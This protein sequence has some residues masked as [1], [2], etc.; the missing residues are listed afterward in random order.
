MKRK[1]LG[2]DPDKLFAD[3]ISLRLWQAIFPFTLMVLAGF[4][5]IFLYTFKSFGIDTTHSERFGTFVSV[6]GLAS[7]VAGASLL[8]GG[9]LGFLFGVP[10]TEDNEFIQKRDDDI[11]FSK[12]ENEKSLTRVSRTNIRA[13]TNLEQISD[14]LTKILVGVGLTQIKP[15]LE[16]IYAQVVV[17][18]APGFELAGSTRDVNEGLTIGVLVYF[19]ASGFFIGYV[20]AR[21]YLTE[22][23]EYGYS[24]KKVKGEVEEERI[25]RDRIQTIRQLIDAIPS[26]DLVNIYAYQQ[27]TDRKKEQYEYVRE[28]INKLLGNLPGRDDE[29]LPGNLDDLMTAI[30]EDIPYDRVFDFLRSRDYINLGVLL[31]LNDSYKMA[32]DFYKKAIRM[33][34]YSY[35][36]HNQLGLGFLR[37]GKYNDAIESLNKAIDINSKNYTAWLNK[38]YVLIQEVLAREA[39]LSE[40]KK[41]AFLEEKKVLAEEAKEYVD[42]AINLSINATP[43]AYVNKGCALSLLSEYYREKNSNEKVNELSKEELECYEKAL[44]M[45]ED[46]TLAWYNF[47]CYHATLAR[48]SAT[49]D[50]QESALKSAFNCL[51]KSIQINSDMKAVAQDDSDLSS[52]KDYPDFKELV[53]E[54]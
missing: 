39:V 3:D 23:L 1:I 2:L 25:K 16:F 26:A 46:C 49:P 51:E 21:V 47:A 30:Y 41:Q 6:F 15:I 27:K 22:S 43:I 40:Q 24:I 28:G 45:D 50:D 36:A 8:V 32:V 19:S 38:G 31:E 48:Y 13:N 7:I 35:R 17:R 9:L 14:W 10:R 42:K 11:S 37:L 12:K 44:E 4:L 53:S 52:L 54:V 20:W 5:F 33:N 34:K 18:L 29:T